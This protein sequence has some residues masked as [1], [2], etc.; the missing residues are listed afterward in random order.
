MILI[1][2]III[3]II[4]AYHDSLLISENQPI[5]HK[6]NAI[7]YT[8]ICI[9]TTI[10]DLS[11][12]TFFALLI[13]R[14]PIFNTMLNIF[15]G[16]PYNYIPKDPQSYIDKISRPVIYLLGYDNYNL[17]LILLSITLYEI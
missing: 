4:L 7:L 2:F 3:N 14:I 16:L 5:N 8:L 13:I 1:I 15:R 11:I 17:S 10:F 9:I 12:M 6:L